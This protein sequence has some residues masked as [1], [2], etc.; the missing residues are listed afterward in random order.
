MKKLL[1]TISLLLF[2]FIIHTNVYA[3]TCSIVNEEGNPITTA[4]AGDV[5]YLKASYVNVKSGKMS[6]K[7]TAKVPT[8]NSKNYKMLIDNSG[9]YYHVGA[10]QE[11]NNLIPIAIPAF[12]YIK[13]TVY[14]IYNLSKA[15][16]C[17]LPL[18]ISEV[19][20]N[21]YTITATAGDNGSITPS[22]DITVNHGDNQSFTISPAT[23]YHVADVVV[24][25]S[26]VGTVTSYTFNNVTANHI[27]SVTFAINAGS[28]GTENTGVILDATITPTYRGAITSS[29]D[30]FQGLCDAGPPPVYEV[31]TEHGANVTLSARLINPN[32]TIQP[33][34]LYIQKYTI[35]YFPNSDSIGAPP[36]ETLVVYK[37]D[38]Y[39][40]P[41][42]GTGTSTLTTPVVLLNLAMKDKY[43][44]DM[45]SGAYPSSVAFLNNYTAI[46]TFEGLNELG[47]A[48]CFEAEASFQIADFDNCD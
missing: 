34:N 40:T 27:I 23:N 17:S 15:G 41:P 6:W 39:I 5:V 2:T 35:K 8:I 13:G 48:F 25:G 14:F 45:L 47:V 18:Y 42:I 3:F 12:D 24:D 32:T 30:A 46:Y 21:T 1:L 4:K 28:C 9:Y 36:I 38:M 26:S 20:P 11:D 31:F 37:N 7:L 44:N 22:G 43:W 29:V 10:S 19:V 16:K 33:S